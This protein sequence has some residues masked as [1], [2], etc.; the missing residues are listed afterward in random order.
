VLD[1]TAPTI[2]SVAASG[3]TGSS[4]NVTWTTSEPSTSRVSNGLTTAFGSFT[5]LDSTL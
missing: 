2:S 5:P 1:T 4:A 3:I